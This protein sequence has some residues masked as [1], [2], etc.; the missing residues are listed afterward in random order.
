MRLRFAFVCVS[1]ILFAFTG[2]KGRSIQT[3]RGQTRRWRVIV[4][5]PEQHLARPRI[6]DPAVET[7]LCRRLINEGYK[8]IDQDRIKDLRYSAV[9]DRIIQGGPKA[10]QEARQIGR[11][12]GADLFITGEAFSQLVSREREETDIGATDVI[13]CRARVELK[14]IRMDTGERFYADSVTKTGSADLTEELA[15]K[16]SLEEAGK[17]LGDALVEKLDR[18]AFSADQSVELEV[19]G[20][21]SVSLA[22]QLEAALSKLPGVLEVE[23]GDFDARVYS[24]EL[25]VSKAQLRN[26]AG[27]LET[28]S[29]LKRFRMKVQSSNGS[30]IVAK[31]H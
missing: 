1:L 10:T 24:T 17:V 23:P 29:A 13:R 5:V 11:R 2:L 27:L 15:S 9:V 26:L 16:T 21:A 4:I 18:L 6:P 30:R 19:R 22:H 8:V 3:P 20:V 28:A 12:F 14:G 31:S 25:R 7:A